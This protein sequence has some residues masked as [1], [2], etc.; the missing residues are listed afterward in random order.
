MQPLQKRIR[1]P[2]AVIGDVHGQAAE[3]RVVLAKLRGLPDFQDRWLV[4]LGDF[5][6]R[7]PQPHQ[8]LEAVVALRR[9]HPKLTAIAGNHDLAVAGALGLVH[10]PPACNWPKRWLA[11]YDC[12]STFA[13]YGV[14]FGDLRALGRAMPRE[15]KQFLAGLPWAIEHPQ[16]L[17]VHAGLV[18]DMPLAEQLTILRRRDF[19]M[20]RPPWLC[21]P[22]L[23]RSAVPRDCPLT[24][25]SGHVR[26][27]RVTF[28]DRRVLLDTTGGMAGDLSAVLL[29]E[30][31]VVTSAPERL[32]RTPAPTD[33]VSTAAKP[34]RLR[35]PK[36]T[37]PSPRTRRAAR[38]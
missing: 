32:A 34:G 9:E 12:G 17:I 33:T 4:F 26:V 8:A 2:L 13:S 7:G 15:H 35:L 19:S 10:A 1:G 16:Y 37:A 27:S 20:N 23:A 28:T 38:R 24:M 30:G 31:K 29:P 3:L 5:L 14:P 11:A 21:D 22:A 6:D 25:V 36:K 18:P